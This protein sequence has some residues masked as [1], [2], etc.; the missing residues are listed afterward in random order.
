MNK[1]Q[2]RLL[3]IVV[4]AIAAYVYLQQA[5]KQQDA[6]PAA[7]SP[8]ATATAAPGPGLRDY[9]VAKV[10]VM[11]SETGT[12]L[13]TEQVEVR[14]IP[15]NI[16][17]PDDSIA[18]RNYDQIKD[19]RLSQPIYAGEIVL[20]TRF[21]S[22]AGDDVQKRLR[23]VIKKDFRAISL[24]VDAVTG[25]TGFI[26]QNDI[27]D[28]VATYMSGGKQLTRIIIQ[29][30]EVLAKGGEYRT[31]TR[32][33][34]E[35]IVR[36]ESAGIVFTLMVKP[37]MA[38]KLAHIIDERGQNR[39]RLILKNKLDGAEYKTPGVLL[40]EVVT[41]QTR[42]TRTQEIAEA[43]DSA[44]IEILRGPGKVRESGEEVPYGLPPEGGAPK[45]VAAAGA[46]ESDS[47]APPTV[48]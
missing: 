25:T 22:A 24:D 13:T 16:P 12:R 7:P 18:V 26:N 34:P 48:K 35:R 3:T 1:Q 9:L 36:G 30:V 2:A 38:A 4:A 45:E 8:M 42:P 29:N 14:S 41:G 6:Q 17:V 39:F 10:S 21:V 11:P 44:E 32:P 37:Q 28:V 43:D 20:K 31:A 5:K 19:I 23:D 27:V 40:R 15:D 33:N 47:A 46:P